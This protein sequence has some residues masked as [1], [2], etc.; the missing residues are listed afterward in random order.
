MEAGGVG[1][2]EEGP[3]DTNRSRGAGKDVGD[4]EVRGVGV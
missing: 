4:G 2:W 1:P 3:G